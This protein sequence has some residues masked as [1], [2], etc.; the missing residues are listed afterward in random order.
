MTKSA[1]V[2]VGALMVILSGAAL[3]YSY[4][5]HPH[6]MTPETIGSTSW[7]VIHGL[8]ALSL[9][10]GLLGTTALYAPTAERSGAMGAIGYVMLF[11]GMML[12]FGLDYYETLIAPYLAQNYPQ[13][14]IDHG[15]G[16]GMGLIALFFPLAGALTVGGYALL[17]GAWMRARVISMEMGVALIMAS[18]LF[19]LGLSPIGDLM[20]ARITAALFGAALIAIGVCALR[21]AASSTSAVWA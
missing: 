5:S 14:V 17:G 12:I 2:R 6:H 15:A 13:V 11:I 8:F 10:F 7:I 18:I 1:F 20:T 19:G 9:I 21:R 4:V 16:D 3:G